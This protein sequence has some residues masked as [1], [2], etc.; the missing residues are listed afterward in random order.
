VPEA[1]G[2]GVKARRLRLV[3]E[4]VVGIGSIAVLAW[5]TD[6]RYGMAFPLPVCA[7]C[8]QSIVSLP[9]LNFSHDA[10]FAYAQHRLQA[11]SVKHVEPGE[12]GDALSGLDP[13]PAGN[14]S[15]K[16]QQRRTCRLRACSGSGTVEHH[17]Q[18]TTV[19]NVSARY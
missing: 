6:D 17:R 14:R 1:L 7:T 15:A 13:S 4:R 12:W 8:P 9:C 16:R 2:D 19:T 10:G 5:L 11:L 18:S 3:P